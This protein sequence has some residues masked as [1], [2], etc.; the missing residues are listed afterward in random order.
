MPYKK[1]KIHLP[2]GLKGAKLYLFV[3]PSVQRFLICS[4]ALQLFM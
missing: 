3:Q 1:K 2:V 4:Q